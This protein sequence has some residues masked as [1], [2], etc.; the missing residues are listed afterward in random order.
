MPRTGPR[1]IGT[2]GYGAAGDIPFPDATFDVA[3]GNQS[4]EHWEEGHYLQTEKPGY[5]E[6]LAEVWRVLKP[7]GAL[8]LDAPIHLHGHEMFVVG[9]IAR[10]LGLFDPELWQDVVTER[11]RYDHSPLAPYATPASDIARWPI[12]VKTY[13]AEAVDAAKRSTVWLLTVTAR[14]R[15]SSSG[16]AESAP[17]EP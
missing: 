8:Y 7:G 6:C 11:W 9:D 12:F 10:V 4:F 2:S 3:F 1:R 14:K 15:G 13:G 16:A 5:R 17:R